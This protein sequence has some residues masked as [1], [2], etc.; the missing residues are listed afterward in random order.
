MGFCRMFYWHWARRLNEKKRLVAIRSH[1]LELAPRWN[2]RG[3]PPLCT[4]PPFIGA[5]ALETTHPFHF[6]MSGAIFMEPHS[7]LLVWAGPVGQTQEK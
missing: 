4:G 6:K 2:G 1:G 7:Y 5:P 3:D